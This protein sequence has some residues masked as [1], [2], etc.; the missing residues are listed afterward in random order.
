MSLKDGQDPALFYQ[1]VFAVASLGL[2]AW[3]LYQ[4]IEPFL[5]PLAWAVLV[6]VLLF[7]LQRRLTTLC[8]GRENLSAAVLTA[9]VVLMFVGPLTALAVAFAAQAGQLAELVPVWVARAEAMITS[10]SVGWLARL[11][12]LVPV[13]AAEL[14]QWAA[15]GARQLLQRAASAGGSAFLGA[16]GT[17]L[18]FTVMLFL[19]FFF[20]RDGALIATSALRLVPVREERKDALVRQLT[21]V[22]QAVVVGTILTAIVQGLL[23]GIGFAIAGLPAP[24]VFGVIGGVLSVVPF[25]GT[26]LVWVPGVI[27]LLVA[28]DYTW[29][30]F[31]AAWGAILVSS[32]DNFLKPLLISG[33][34]E[35]PTLAVFIGVLGGLSAFG[36][37]GMFLGPVVIALALALARL[38][39]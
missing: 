10:G 25:G 17:I 26:A 18:S 24:V 28:G 1:R 21:A 12:T 7:P 19:L 20:L 15:A 14:Q 16:V 5:K 11:Q 22:T 33:R 9:L 6:A 13:E 27:A 37:V 23:L 4:V 31:L 35:V 29:G 8:R 39:D 34:A 36:L 2:L 32:V 38:R 30:V 3:L